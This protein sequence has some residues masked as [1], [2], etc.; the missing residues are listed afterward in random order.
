MG[1]MARARLQILAVGVGSVAVLFGLAVIAVVRA[2]KSSTDRG[3]ADAA[4]SAPPPATA[5]PAPR[6]VLPAAA[7]V[8]ADAPQ[9]DARQLLLRVLDA[10]SGAPVTN[11]RLTRVSIAE[12]SR[13][14]TNTFATDAQGTGAIFYSPTPVKYWSHR[15]EIFRDGYVP[16][17]VSWSESQQDRID[18]IPRE[19]TVKIDRPVTIG[20]TVMDEQDRP[21]PGVRVVFSVSGPSVGASRARERLTLMGNYHTEV[22]D[23]RGR[24]SCNHV[25]A[26]FGMIDYKPIHPQF[27]EKDY[28]S[29]S[30]QS[31]A[32]V[33]VER[34]SE[35]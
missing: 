1:A 34:I 22:T 8:A 9:P 18:E 28:A 6:R 3:G 26:R 25:P 20:G 4:A 24:W 29:D 32:Y 35:A 21:V 12:L 27:Q 14:T 17:Y 19:H 23:A 13:R 7:P 2:N 30:P 10:Q 11:A 33:N 15:I 31:A 5:Q 16:K